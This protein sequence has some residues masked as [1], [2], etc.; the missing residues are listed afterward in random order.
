MKTK[1]FRDAEECNNFLDHVTRSLRLYVQWADQ[2]IELRLQ[3]KPYSHTPALIYGFS[4]VVGTI[5]PACVVHIQPRNA[6]RLTK[7]L[8]D[9]VAMIAHWWGH[10]TV[11]EASIARD[12][13]APHKRV[14]RSR[15]GTDVSKIS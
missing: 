15:I 2:Q 8:I 13:G 4:S 12:L 14:A 11:I 7:A 5:A 3:G 9:D 10:K 1:K 6:T